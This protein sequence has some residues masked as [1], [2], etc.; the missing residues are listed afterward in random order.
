MVVAHKSSLEITNTAVRKLSQE[1][2]MALQKPQGRRLGKG[3]HLHHSTT[4][5]RVSYT[6]YLL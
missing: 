2:Y 1:K 4:L 3:G 6:V 5:Q